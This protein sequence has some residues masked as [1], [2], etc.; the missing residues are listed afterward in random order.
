MAVIVQPPLAAI[1]LI[2]LRAQHARGGDFELEA[3]PTQELAEISAPSAKRTVLSPHRASGLPRPA[4]LVSSA[5]PLSP[6]R[7]AP[8][9]AADRIEQVRREQEHPGA[10]AAQP[11]APPTAPLI[12]ADLRFD[13]DFAGVL[14]LLNS[15]IALDLYPDFTR[16]LGSRLAPSPSWLLGQVGRRLLGPAFG[17][18]SLYSWL[19]NNAQPG[20]LPDVWQIAEDWEPDRARSRRYRSGELAVDWDRRGFFAGI[21]RIGRR[22]ASRVPAPRHIARLL[23]HRAAMNAV[24]LSGFVEYLRYRL[25]QADVGLSD[26]RLRGTIALVEGDLTAL[27]A[28]AD[29]PIAVRMAGLDRD[30]GWLPAEGRVLRFEFV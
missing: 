6:P 22:G 13:T 20:R 28:L 4:M 14:F 19:T 5:L 29:L 16:P 18:D 21:H 11:I 27:I 25:N 1:A 12:A 23:P 9:N 3:A 7:E 8:P 15:F 2:V 17:R 26:L 10:V 30:P 24:W